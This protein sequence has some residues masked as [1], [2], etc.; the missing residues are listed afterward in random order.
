MSE[1]EDIAIETI[2][3]ETQGRGEQKKNEWNHFPTPPISLG[4]QWIFFKGQIVNIL[5]FWAI[6][7]GQSYSTA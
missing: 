1:V 7:F 3:N 5:A 2:Q 4:Q 6:G